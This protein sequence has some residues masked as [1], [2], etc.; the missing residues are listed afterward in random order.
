MKS[1]LNTSLAAQKRERHELI[2]HHQVMG[3][4]IALCCFAILLASTTI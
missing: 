1:Y 3:V 2:K 4:S